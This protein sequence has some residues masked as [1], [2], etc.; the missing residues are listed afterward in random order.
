MSDTSPCYARPLDCVV[1][2]IPFKNDLLERKAIAER[3]TGYIDRLSV[4]CVMGIDAPWGEGKTYFGRNWEALLSEQGYKTIYLDAFEQDFSD[5]PFLVISAEILA[6]TKV[7]EEEDESWTQLKNAVVN[8]GKAVL[9]TATK[10]LVNGVGK[11]ILG[12][13]DLA[14]LKDKFS[15][16][17][18]DKLGDAA[19]QYVQKRLQ[20]YDQEKETALHFRQALTEFTSTQE[21]PVVFFIDELD[22][23]RPT[24]AVQIIERI[25]HFFDTPNLVFVLMINREQLEESIKGIYGAGIDAHA[26]LGK[27]VHFFLKLPKRTK[28][29]YGRQNYNVSYSHYLAQHYKLANNQS[30]QDFAECLGECASYL[31]LSLRDLEK[32]YIHF[33]IAQPLN[34]LAV[35]S[36]YVICL[37]IAKPDLYEKI[38]KND[39]EGHSLALEMVSCWLEI[40]PE[41]W[42]LHKLE[43]MH[44]CKLVGL[45]ELDAEEK[46][47][48]FYISS[49]CTLRTDN[50][51]KFIAKKI[52]VVITD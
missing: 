40:N 48:L 37:K 25:K 18:E 30:M 31:N 2:G 46:Q 28:T 20:E 9:P 14:E 44:K 7:E 24:F 6:A 1:D 51:F 27:F 32:A 47:E 38:V 10:L 4:G 3:L 12:T 39:I 22:R 41:S 49:S 34:N 33:V 43:I 45:D 17:F 11:W 13:S 19:E 5:D 16:I 21:K 52:D 15:D 50:I 42:L 36:A 29:E 8:T 35:F 23:C 26:Y